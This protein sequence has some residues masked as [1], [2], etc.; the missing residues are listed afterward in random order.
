MSVLHLELRNALR[1]LAAQPGFSALVIGVLAAGLACVL[2][3]LVVLNSM[4]IR[5][6]PFAAPEQLLHL[7]FDHPKQS[8]DLVAAHDRD[9][10][11]WQE[12]LAGMA[13]VAAYQEMTVNLGDA[14]GT[15]RYAGARI[16]PNLFNLLGSVPQLGRGFLPSDG[17]P[18]AP[19]TVV[20]S[21]ALWRNRFNA[22]PAISGRHLRVN[23]AD[24]TV[25]GVMPPDFSFPYKEQVWLAGILDAHAA[26]SDSAEW[27]VIAR[28]HA[29][30]RL[31]ALE[32]TL[33]AWQTDAR[34]EAPRYFEERTVAVEPLSW[35]FVEPST[36]GILNVML[37]AVILVLL[38]ACANAANLMLTR[39]LA[40]RQEL[41]VRAALGASRRRLVVHLLC[42]SLLL[43]TVACAIALPLGWLGAHWVDQMFRSSE[44]GPPRW[45]HFAL[46]ANLILFAVLAALATGLITGLLPALR[47]GS[48]VNEVLRD[49]SRAVAGGHFAKVSRAL[50]I[51]EIA[52]SCILLVAAGVLV[53]GIG[54]FQDRDFGIRPQGLLTARVGLPEALYPRGEQQIA[55]FE[56]LSERLRN[57]PEVLD[58]GMGTTLPG[59]ISSWERV[60]AAGASADDPRVLAYTGAID[61]HFASTYALRLEE[62]RLF[63][64]ADRADT[65][66]VAI[67][68]RTFAERFGGDGPMLGRQFAINPDDPDSATVT[69]VGVIAPT[70][71][72]DLDD[73][74]RPAI[75]FPLRQQPARFVSIAVRTRGEPGAFATRLTDIVREVDADAPAYWVRTYDKVMLEAIFG[76][77]VLA[78]LF[79]AFGLVALFLAAA[80]LYGVIAFSVRQRTREIGVR[81]ALGAPTARLLRGLL[82]SGALQV[83]V[84]LA[85]GLGLAWP[86][87]RLLV[88]SLQG[89]EAA[90]PLVYALVLGALGVVALIAI[91]L[92]ARRALRV[93]P[94]VALR[95]E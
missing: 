46:D 60:A 33:A 56:R 66:P 14:S 1:S 20:L 41:A 11:A 78:K 84:G 74:A 95:H 24:A 90:D 19:A 44:E 37:L 49:D 8:S 71:L 82:R 64:A 32:A 83:G 88:R 39:A 3:M 93:D 80:G 5:P 16:T 36:R 47:A 81:R 21:D 31:A 18:G 35:L 54:G 69:V 51:G 30:T 26:R 48:S 55:L 15:E 67:V 91:V 50:V 68:D 89:F 38:V 40:R 76:Q 2:F 52:L 7:G 61:D 73:P 57:D 86:F 27:T 45:M 53:R 12:R 65:M 70:Q 43:A 25:I 13:D 87:A 75:L 72:D 29:D 9:V 6:L 62:G 59:L 58:A 85:L 94:V 77:Q 79:T 34:R 22:D 4:V 10:H 17:K 42:Q 23:A 28:R 92:P 63:N